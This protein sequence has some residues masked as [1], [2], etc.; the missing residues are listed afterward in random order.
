MK[1]FAVEYRKQVNMWVTEHVSAKA[2]SEEDLISK[3]WANE[4]EDCI[5]ENIRYDEDYDSLKVI[6][7]NHM[8]TIDSIYPISEFTRGI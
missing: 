8:D 2:I 5:V 4:F 3:L 7:V 6:K 1:Q